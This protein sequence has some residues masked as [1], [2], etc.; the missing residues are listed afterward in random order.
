MI[1]F[2]LRSPYPRGQNPIT[3]MY[4]RLYFNSNTVWQNE[5]SSHQAARNQDTILVS[6][7][8]CEQSLDKNHLPD[9]LTQQ[10]QRSVKET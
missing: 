4:L 7:I 3:K 9:S 2:T 8:F 10:Y 1:T 6:E 5:H